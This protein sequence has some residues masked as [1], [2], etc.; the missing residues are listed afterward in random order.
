MLGPDL[1]GG[2]AWWLSLGVC[3]AAALAGCQPS[4]EPPTRLSDW[5]QLS[6]HSGRLVLANDVVP[7][8]LNTPLFS[9]YAHK[10]RTVWLPR[11]THAERVGNNIR[12][13]VGTVFTK[14][15]FYP[16][17][18]RGQLLKQL[19][20]HTRTVHIDG[21]EA[22][23]ISH[24]KLIETRLLVRRP[25]GWLTLAYQWNDEQTR[26]VLRRAGALVPLELH[27]PQSQAVISDTYLIPNQLQCGNCHNR[28]YRSGQSE[29]LGPRIDHLDRDYDYANGNENQLLH[30]VRIGYLSG[31]DAAPYGPD[32]DWEQT[33]ATLEARARAYL[34]V[35]CGHCHN[36]GG[37][38]AN[39]TLF[40]DAAEDQSSLHYGI[41]KRPIAAGRA[42]GGRLMDIVPGEPDHSI[43]LYRM[44]SIEPGVMMPEIGRGAAHAEGI[45]LIRA[46]IASFS[47]QCSH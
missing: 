23:D 6:I 43:M 4:G 2:R 41:C 34:D 3:A 16:T 1:R 45:A 44:A 47:S 18:T 39:T 37:A 8:D 27:D 35:N 20:M 42:T 40:L 5:H 30:L 32:A 38:A 36:P 25:E 28:D 12:F 33:G 22:L 31:L 26:A 21:H 24:V 14:T 46:W 13:P 19:D 29:P 9:D 17:D 10:L 15:F 11:G 7:F